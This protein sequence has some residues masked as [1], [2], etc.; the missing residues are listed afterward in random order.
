MK[1]IQRRINC[2]FGNILRYTR[3]IWQKQWLFCPRINPSEAWYS[4][5]GIATFYGLD[6]PGI[7]SRWGWDFPQP[8]RPVL[9]PTQP[10]IQWA[11]VFPGDKMAGSWR[12]P[13]TPSSA[14][15]KESVELYLYS[16]SGHSWP[17]R[18]WTLTFINP[19]AG[20]L[21]VGRSDLCLLLADLTEFAWSSYFSD[22]GPLPKILNRTYK[23][24]CRK[25]FSCKFYTRWVFRTT[26]EKF[27]LEIRVDS[28][29]EQMLTAGQTAV[30]FSWR[31]EG[32]REEKSLST[33]YSNISLCIDSSLKYNSIS[34][35]SS[36]CANYRAQQAP[37]SIALTVLCTAQTQIL[38]QVANQKHLRR[39]V[40]L[41]DALSGLSQ[42]EAQAW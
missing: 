14:E 25:H 9:G 33:D 2:Y 6:G 22:Y 1:C 24:L 7:E 5:V 4:A 27:M 38:Q 3:R 29:D 35:F 23:L 36:I 21:N 16:P 15:I 11:P 19:S 37:T 13:P 32:E 31:T 8:S 28:G 20:G 42:W 34:G 39:F 17:V 12:W 10:R 40:L 26:F 18:G 30:S 41:W